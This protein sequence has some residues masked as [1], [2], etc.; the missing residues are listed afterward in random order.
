MRHCLM[1]ALTTPNSTEFFQR[2]ISVSGVGIYKFHKSFVPKT[3]PN[4]KYYLE[5]SKHYTD[6]I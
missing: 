2:V 3:R 4:K 5:F 6:I 1:M